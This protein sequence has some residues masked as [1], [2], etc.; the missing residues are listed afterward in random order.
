MKNKFSMAMSLAVVLAMLLTSLVLAA[1][2]FTAEVTG[3][4]NDV[5]V[6]QG[7]GAVSSTIQLS[8]TGSI[9]N[10]IT[11]ANSSTAQVDTV[12][13]L[14][15]GSLSTGTSSSAMKFYSTGVGCSGGN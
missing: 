13:T 10:L 11:A 7:G 1:E 2:L 6:V 15:G 5:T 4:A 14:T 3:T 12:Y 8:A 9:S